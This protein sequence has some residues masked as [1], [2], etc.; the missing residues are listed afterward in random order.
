M[1]SVTTNFEY[2]ETSVES[3]STNKAEEILEQPKVDNPKKE[4]KEVKK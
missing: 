2:K 1:P 3:V 4:E